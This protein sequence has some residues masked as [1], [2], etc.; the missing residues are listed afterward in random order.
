MIFL[1]EREIKFGIFPNGETHIPKETV[2]D[3]WIN[4]DTNRI[5]LFY[6]NDKDIMNLIFLK[7]HLDNMTP[8]TKLV[9]VIP[10]LPYSRMD[11]T[12]GKT[13]FTLKSICKLINNMHFNDVII[14]EPHSDV[15]VAL[16]DRVTVVNSTMELVMNKVSLRDDTYLVFPDAGAEKRYSKQTKWSKILTC[17]KER[18]FETGYIKRLDING[19][20]PTLSFDAVIVDDLCSKGGTFI[21]TAQ[22]LKE[23]GA[24]KI[25]LVVTHC[26]K[27]ILDGDI[28][29]TDLIDE[30]ITTNSI[31]KKEDVKNIEK[32]KVFEI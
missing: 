19:Q 22:K 32:I 30:V 3:I 26:E 2:Q 15:S 10:Y 9:L 23:I 21:L 31:I 29:K 1:N 14:F 24:E 20:V 16:L 12:E 28:F 8:I 25:T 5:K 18:D 13:F 11:R 27:T 7:D 4:S 17:S 6:E